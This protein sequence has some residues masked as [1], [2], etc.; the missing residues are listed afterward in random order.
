[1]VMFFSSLVFA[2]ATSGF[3]HLD[4][5]PWP[6]RLAVPVLIFICIYP[7]LKRFTRWCHYY[8]GIALGLAPVCAWVAIAGNIAPEPAILGLAVLCWTAGFDILYACQDY[9]SDL[10]TRIHS[11]PAGL[12]IARA[13]TVA[14]LTHIISWLLLVA[15]WWYFPPLSTW[16]AIGVLI[17]GALLLYEHSLVRADDLSRL[18]IAFFTLNGLISCILGLCG[19]IDVLTAG[20]G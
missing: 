13:L 14:K 2:L 19:I 7:L 17:A 12:G 20:A 10:Q 11:V 4:Q 5:N 18:N 15:L 9:Q 1:M 8:L 16:F 3:W 6:A